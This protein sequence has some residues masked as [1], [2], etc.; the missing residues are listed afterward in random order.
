MLVR[1]TVCFEPATLGITTTSGANT[2]ESYAFQFA[3]PMG[4]VQSVTSASGAT[5][6]YTYSDIN[7]PLTVAPVPDLIIAVA[8]VFGRSVQFNY[9]ASR[10]GARI[11]RI[12]DPAG[13]VITAGY[14]PNGMLSVLT[15]PDGTARRF[16]YELA[17]GLP[18]ALTGVIDEN[19][20]R[21]STYAYDHNGRAVQT[22]L[23]GGV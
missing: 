22:Q 5:I 15:W 20:R 6:N 9:E 16:L 12:I 13:Q 11:T 17:P 10:A 14:D 21:F 3:D 2:L 8:D 19:F 18:W 7:T 4:K 1:G 23:A